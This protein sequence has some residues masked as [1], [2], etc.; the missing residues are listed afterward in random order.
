MKNR[1]HEE[2]FVKGVVYLLLFAL[3]VFIGISFAMPY[4]RYYAFK[5]QAAGYM[6]ME[7]AAPDMIKDRIVEYV[8]ESNLPVAE[9]NISITQYGTGNLLTASWSE[10][11]N[12]FGYY[13]KELTFNVELE[14]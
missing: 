4:Y 10:E 9:E 1:S 14:N 12:L 6:K 13:Q 11:V 7:N 2:G 8:K 5:T 3:L